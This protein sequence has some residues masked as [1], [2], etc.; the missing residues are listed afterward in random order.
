MPR[1]RES[2][3]EEIRH[4]NAA[5]DVADKELQLS[6]AV[7]KPVKPHVARLR[8]LRLDGPIGKAYC[9]CDFIVAVDHRGALG[10]AKVVQ[11]RPV[12]RRSRSLQR[13]C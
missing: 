11:E 2:L 1:K 6:H 3:G 5:R 12:A 8:E 9:Y 13:Q 10:I 4:V 7:P